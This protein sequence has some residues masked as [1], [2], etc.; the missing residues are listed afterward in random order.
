MLGG[1]PT[2]CDFVNLAHDGF[3]TRPVAP[4]HTSLGTIRPPRPL[5][6]GFAPI[7]QTGSTNVNGF[8]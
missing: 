8:E 3:Y 1:L 2:T 6:L 4:P 7:L 5:R